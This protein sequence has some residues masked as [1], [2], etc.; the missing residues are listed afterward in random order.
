MSKRRGSLQQGVARSVAARY[1]DGYRAASW[2][3]ATGTM[4]K[5]AAVIAATLLFA[6][7]ASRW[8]QMLGSVVVA[9]GVGLVFWVGGVFTAAQ[10]Q[11]L[12]A[13]LDTAV[14]SSPFLS[15]GQRAEVMQ[16]S[17]GGSEL[18]ED[19]DPLP[20]PNSTPVSPLGSVDGEEEPV[21]SVVAEFCYHCGA[22]LKGATAKCPACGKRL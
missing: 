12:K 1:Q 3:I 16:L 6:A 7:L 13:I 5:I 17:P 21:G 10:G 15:E 19:A 8:N 22:T 20:S 9:F 2:I 11:L 4:L 18:D 14:N